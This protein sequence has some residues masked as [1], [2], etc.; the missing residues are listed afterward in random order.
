M[1][2]TPGAQGSRAHGAKK[3]RFDFVPSCA[4]VRET[5]VTETSGSGIS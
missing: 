1:N 2:F 3:I 5:V 4:P